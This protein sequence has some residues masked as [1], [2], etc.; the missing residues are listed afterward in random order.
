MRGAVMRKVDGITD[1]Q[2][3]WT[4]DG[5]LTSLIGIVNHLIHVEWRWIDGAMLQ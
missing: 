5:R 1:E 4:P 3:R 2:A